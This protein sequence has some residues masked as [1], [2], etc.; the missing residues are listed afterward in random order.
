MP[1]KI[2]DIEGIGTT[3]AAKLNKQDIYT[4][5]D[6]LTHC[7]TKQGR[8]KIAGIT[9]L[10]ESLLLTWVNHCD[11]MRLKGV[12]GQISELLEAAGVDSVPELRQR[13]ASNLY[14]KLLQVNEKFGLSGK[15]PSIE[16]LQNM[17][18]QAKSLPAVVS[19]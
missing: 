17:I 11:L 1:Y 19:H 4:T 15:V 13:N 2:V 7:G 9:H 8:E 16:E 5:T 3:Y 18:E 14:E 10:P 12:A 6:L